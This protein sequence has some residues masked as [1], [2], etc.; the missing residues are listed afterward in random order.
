MTKT[1]QQLI[2]FLKREN[3]IK[4]FAIILIIVLISGS[5]IAIFE[6]GLSLASGVWWSIVTL[7][8]VGYGDISPSTTGGRILAVII[9]F[10]GIGLLG[11]LSASLATLLIRKRMKED[12]G[13]CASTVDN[14]IIICEWNHRTRAIIK[15][16]R[17]D[18]QTANVPLIL[19]AD[20]EEKPT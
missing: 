6:P 18:T 1:L 5:L 9:I 13:M 16:L 17:A 12:K 11:M 3:V 7:T 19:I 10:F 2:L 15:E 4:L 20:I 8:T 14:H